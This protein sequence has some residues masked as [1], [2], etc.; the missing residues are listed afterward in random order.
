MDNPVTACPSSCQHDVSRDA[1]HPG[2]ELC[3]VSFEYDNN[4][5]YL[6]MIEGGSRDTVSVRGFKTIFLEGAAGTRLDELFTF[7]FRTSLLST[8]A[9]TIV[10][11]TIE[12][13]KVSWTTP[14][15]S[16]KQGNVQFELHMIPYASCDG[17]SPHGALLKIGTH[18][19]V[20]SIASFREGLNWLQNLLATVGIV[21]ILIP[22]GIVL[23]ERIA[24][25]NITV[26][27]NLKEHTLHM[28][29]SFTTGPGIAPTS[30]PQAN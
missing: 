12:S 5:Y 16:A 1:A 17:V 26:D 28:Q 25:G 4:S 18:G 10:Q 24:D 23:A 2:H 3:T 20:A 11:G 27:V 14:T 22:P 6:M 13:I 21:A 8:F 7:F 9:N 29:G 15:P 30:P 19:P